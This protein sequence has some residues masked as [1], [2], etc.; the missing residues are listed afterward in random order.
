VNEVLISQSFDV[1]IHESVD[2]VVRK[3]FFTLV[4]QSFQEGKTD[5]FDAVIVLLRELDYMLA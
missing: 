5:C 4:C 1:V 3:P 2:V